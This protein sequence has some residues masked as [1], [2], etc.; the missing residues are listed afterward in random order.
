MDSSSK[1]LYLSSEDK[2][3]HQTGAH[4]FTIALTAPLW[5]ENEGWELALQ[6][7]HFVG[8]FTS[9]PTPKMISVC[10]DIAETSMIHNSQAKILRRLTNSNVTYVH[11]EYLN[12]QYKRIITTPVTSVR[13]YLLT[14]K[15]VPAVLSPDSW[16]YCTLHLRKRNALL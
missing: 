1:Y 2:T 15:G 4:D 7:I 13:V 14:E 10:C 8:K 9:E 3:L 16:L 11:W 12:L 6:S 5:L